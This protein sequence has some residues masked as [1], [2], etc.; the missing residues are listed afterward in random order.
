[1][2]ELEDGRIWRR[3]LDQLRQKC[4]MHSYP[5]AGHAADVAESEQS[6]HPGQLASEAAAGL[7]AA[8][9]GLPRSASTPTNC[10][11]QPAAA[12]LLADPLSPA[13][14]HSSRE[15]SS[16]KPLTASDAAVI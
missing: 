2:V 10:G 12:A 9:E 14:E 3:H 6:L 11:E 8:S 1:M 15:P 5:V 16:V 4:D 13:P 7:P